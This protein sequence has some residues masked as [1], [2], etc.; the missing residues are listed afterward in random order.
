MQRVARGDHRHLTD[1]RRPLLP[2]SMSHRRRWVL[3]VEERR[4]QENAILHPPP[5]EP[6]VRLRRNLVLK[7]QRS[8]EPLG[9]LRH[10]DLP[11]GASWTRK[12]RRRAPARPSAS[13]GDTGS[14]GA[15]GCPQ[16][17]R[18]HRAR[19]LSTDQGEA[20]CTRPFSRIG[21]YSLL[22]LRINYRPLRR[23]AGGRVPG[24]LLLPS[25]DVVP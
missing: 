5:L 14:S 13:V 23:L 6:P 18:D 11:T 8:R 25:A 2:P 20:A 1:V 22:L 12:S 7:V 4:A 9:D 3:R 10:R 21:R 19:R 17:W 16:R 15:L 24:V